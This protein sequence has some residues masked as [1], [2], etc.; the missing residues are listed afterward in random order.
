L[1]ANTELELI[2]PP[3]SVETISLQE[4][5]AQALANNPEVVEAEQNVIKA[6]AATKMSKMDYF[7]AVALI[8]NYSFQQTIPLLPKDFSF[9]GIVAT[10]NLF[11]FGKREHTIKERQVQLEIAAAALAATKARVT[12][13]IAKKYLTLQQADRNRDLMRQQMLSCQKFPVDLELNSPDLAADTE[14][15]RIRADRAVSSRAYLPVYLRRTTITDLQAVI[16]LGYS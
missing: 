13:E 5:T 2:S 9:I 4:A 7:P 1:P 6:R 11:D 14:S 10:Y 3:S 15:V 12:A 16:K 8:G